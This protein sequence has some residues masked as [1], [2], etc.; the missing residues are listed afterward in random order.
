MPTVEHFTARPPSQKP[1]EVYILAL[2]DGRIVA[3]TADEL[4]A[5]DDTT[6]IAAGLPPHGAIGSLTP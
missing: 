4:Q 1:V 2:P 6:R 3:R 5:A